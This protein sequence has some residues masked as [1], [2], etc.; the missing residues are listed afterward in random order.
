MCS[1][2]GRLHSSDEAIVMIE[3]RR[4]PTVQ[5]SGE[6]TSNGRNNP[7]IAKPFC[8]DKWEVVKAVSAAAGAYEIWIDGN[9]PECYFKKLVLLG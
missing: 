2:I 7:Q 6:S 8:I 4:Q 5:Q 3:E 1:E 9:N